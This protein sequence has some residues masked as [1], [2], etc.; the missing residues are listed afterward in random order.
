MSSHRPPTNQW[1]ILPPASIAPETL[2]RAAYRPVSR[3][4]MV[5]AG[6]QTPAPSP[7]TLKPTSQKGSPVNAQP[8]KLPETPPKDQ[9]EPRTSCQPTVPAVG[10]VMPKSP[11]ST[12]IPGHPTAVN[13]VPGQDGVLALPNTGP[14][15]PIPSNEPK[16][17]FT[18]Y[19]PD[20]P[21]NL[22][23][24]RCLMG[25]PQECPPLPRIT[26]H[27]PMF[28][29]VRRLFHPMRRH[30]HIPKWLKLQSC[31]P[32]A[33]SST[34]FA[35]LKEESHT[36]RAFYF[37]EAFVYTTM[38]VQ[39][40][41][42]AN[43]VILG[44]MNRAN[45]IAIATLAAASGVLTGILSLIRGQGL[46]NRLL[47]YADQLR[48]V[49]EDIE[50][51]ERILRTDS[52]TVTYRDCVELREAYEQSRD[53]AVKNHPDSWTSGLSPVAGNKDNTGRGGA[54]V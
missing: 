16:P 29:G 10:P 23:T 40:V 18:L 49:R 34:Y 11:P 22:E 43:L 37:Y 52:G 32:E 17:A 48:R 20:S 51:C 6:S 5:P 15:T 12:F 38:I 54:Q 21:M 26:P 42:A 46:P 39:L 50:W 4:P 13:N 47:Q 44:A 36:W 27:P 35:I 31:H 28:P 9:P 19:S 45:R 33:A 3:F 8:A 53:D 14:T 24:F 30:N 7:V 2:S 1:P 41:I 25:I